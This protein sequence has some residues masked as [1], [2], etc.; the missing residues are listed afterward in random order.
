MRPPIPDSQVLQIVRALIAEGE[1]RGTRRRAHVQIWRTKPGVTYQ[2]TSGVLTLAGPARGV[3]E[4]IE[5]INNFI[6]ARARTL[7]RGERVGR[8][9]DRRSRPLAAA[10]GSEVS[11]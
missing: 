4:A 6:R 7:Q 10:A 1:W 9:R 2:V 3:H 8:G 11:Q 5:E